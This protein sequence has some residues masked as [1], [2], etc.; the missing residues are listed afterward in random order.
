[1]GI[2]TTMMVDYGDLVYQ[3]TPRY[4]SVEVQDGNRLLAGGPR[5]NTY[6]MEYFRLD[7]RYWEL[8]KKETGGDTDSNWQT[9]HFRRRR[10]VDLVVV[11]EESDEKT[12]VSSTIGYEVLD[13]K[14]YIFLSDGGTEVIDEA[15]WNAKKTRFSYPGYGKD[16]LIFT[17]KESN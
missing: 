2:I 12:C 3:Y 8:E 9:L 16:A 1:M 17:R 4:Y 14:Y 11:K 10:S 15:E 13:G 7:L 6:D 5:V